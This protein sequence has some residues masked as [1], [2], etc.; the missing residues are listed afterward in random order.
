MFTLQQIQEAHSKTKTGAD[1]PRYVQELKQLGIVTYDFQ[2]ESGRNVFFGKDGNSVVNTPANIVHRIVSGNASSEKFK[3][4]LEIH[5]KGQTDFQTFCMQ[6]AE[7]GVEKWTSDLIKM[8][9][10]YYDK[11]GNKMHGETI[12]E[13]FK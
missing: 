12:P 1:Y 6:A 2:V 11:N 9:C 8:E 13:G 4:I 10:I 3:H 5:Q 7:A